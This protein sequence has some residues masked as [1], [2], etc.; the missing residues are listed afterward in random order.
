M[1]KLDRY[2]GKL[3]IVVDNEPFEVLFLVRDR[4]QIAAI[5]DMKDM[6]TRAEAMTSLCTDIILRSYP[7]EKKEDIETFL[8]KNMDDFFRKY[9]VEAGLVSREAMEKLTDDAKKGLLQ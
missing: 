9:M 1:G 4:I 6:K 7:S 8:A 3:S 5:Y 2:T